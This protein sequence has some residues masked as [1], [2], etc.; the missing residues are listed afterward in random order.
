MLTFASML[1]IGESIFLH[2]QTE[3]SEKKEKKQKQQQQQN[4]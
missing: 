4:S 2:V 3:I 1:T